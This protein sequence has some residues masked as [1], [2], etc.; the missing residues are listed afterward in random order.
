[1]LQDDNYWNSSEAIV[2]DE[3]EGE[4]DDEEWTLSE[5]WWKSKRR[6]MDRQRKRV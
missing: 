5:R 4:E 6:G 3:M 1:V 2:I